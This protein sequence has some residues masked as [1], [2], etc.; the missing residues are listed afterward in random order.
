[1]NAKAP[2]AP[3]CA[4]LVGPYLSGKTTLLESILVVTGAVNRKGSVTEGNTVG[5]AAPEARTRQMSV[6]VNVATTDYLGDPWTF[7]DCPGSVELAQEAVNALTVVDAAVV[8]CEPD[9]Q[10][11]LA[12]SALLSFL[13]ERRIPHMIFINKM[14]T[15]GSTVK[16][17][18]DALQALSERPLVLRAIPVRE[19]DAVTGHVDLVSEHAFKWTDGSPSE[20]TDIPQSAQGRER[21]ARTEMLEVLANF[22]DPLLEKLLEDEIPDTEEIYA[23][24]T[25]DFQDGAIVPVFFGSTQ[26]G[27]GVRRLL[28]ALRHETP[29]PARTLERLGIEAS[30][31]VVVQ[32][33]KTMNAAGTGK[34]SLGRVWQGEI[35]EGLTLDGSR[36]SGL[37]SLLGHK[38]DKLDKAGVGAVVAMGRMEGVAT[39]AL[40]T[41]VPPPFLLVVAMAPRFIARPCPASC[42]GQRT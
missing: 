34:L 4:A 15:H 25:K 21:E 26:H 37:F 18:L 11:A 24:L 13:G 6:E 5:D 10:K 27:S 20:T 33:F 7:I 30:D 9:T 40:L 35:K 29:E 22:D 12:V 2:S 38:Q 42:S 23:N 8:V 36:I 19:G 17:T 3:R 31:D 39:G 16:G 41:P 1:M 14:D 32:V 28:K